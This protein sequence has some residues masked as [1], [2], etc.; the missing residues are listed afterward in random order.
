MFDQKNFL[1]QIK[2]FRFLFV[3]LVALIGF[4]ASTLAQQATIV[5][6]VTDPSGAVVPNVAVTL[7]IRIRASATSFPRMT[8]AST[9]PSIFRLVTIE[10]KPK[11]K[12][13]RFRNK[14]ISC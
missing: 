14:K 7:R 2:Q 4:S 6:T 10:S 11:P 3:L 1:T 8:P 9:L 13:S 12:D 5:G